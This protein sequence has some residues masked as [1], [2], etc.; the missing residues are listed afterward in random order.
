MNQHGVPWTKV[1]HNIFVNSTVQR[2]CSCSY[3][4]FFIIIIII[5]CF[6]VCV[7]VVEIQCWCCNWSAGVWTCGWSLIRFVGHATGVGEWSL[8][9][10]DLVF[11]PGMHPPNALLKC[12]FSFHSSRVTAAGLRL[13]TCLKNHSKSA[14][15]DG[16]SCI[17]LDLW[18]YLALTNGTTHAQCSSD[19]VL[20]P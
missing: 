16:I 7:C 5:I 3:Y 2:K 20:W 10:I 17:L 9:S 1:L 11:L 13:L 6:C 8:L 14:C 18:S 19:P 15:N 4:L 12:D